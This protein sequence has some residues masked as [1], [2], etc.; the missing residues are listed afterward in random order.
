MAMQ[1]TRR[2]WAAHALTASGWQQDVQIEIG[3]SGLISSVEAGIK[4][5]ATGDASESHDIVVAS[6]ANLHSHAF[7]R[8]MAGMTEARGPDPSDSFWTW[9]KLMYRFLD[10][11]GPDDVEAIAAFVQ[12]EM[13]ES[14]YSSVGEFHYLHHQP[15]GEPYGN[16]AEMSERI[17][18]A[19][20]ITGIGLTLLPVQYEH[21]GCDGRA[22]GAGQRRFGNSAEA[23]IKLHERAAQSMTNL[24]QDCMLGV[25]P[26]SLRAVS[27]EGL[28]SALAV[29]KG[30]PFH[31]HVAEQT[32]EVDEIE[33]AWGARPVQWLLDNHDVCENWCLIH[34]T[35]MQPTE[36]A[37]L[38]ATG[39]VVG[40]CP[41]TESS[42][43]DGIFDGAHYQKQGGAW[44][45]GSDS[46]IRISLS[47]EL[48]ALEYSQR[49]RDRGR[50][51]FA[52]TDR[53]TGRVL[54]DSA[55]MGGARA[56][57]RNTGVLAT[58]HVADLLALDSTH[59]N[60]IAVSDDGWLDSW[61]FSGD[62]TLVTDVWSAGRHVVNEGRHFKHDEI[63]QRYDQTM[64]AVTAII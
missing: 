3:D 6:P 37:G 51:I 56:M 35:Q 33:A 44:G 13:L 4:S 30:S 12:M 16:I 47:E 24:P 45:V 22:L 49:L 38:A 53:S 32:A 7:Q 42:L 23:F 26:H 27:R 57:Q 18:A 54:L 36:T 64:R 25:A 52:E 48:R 39:A 1:L 46:N 15:S 55:L 8:A 11:L 60:M 59:S 58:G 5:A 2:L 34:C 40:L 28:N 63:R 41:I 43:G 62:D 9:R 21:G 19:T 20:A 29:S 50:A 31:I 17:V 10:Q 14:G 61:I